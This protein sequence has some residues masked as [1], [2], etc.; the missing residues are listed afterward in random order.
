MNTNE[1]PLPYQM[2]KMIVAKWI[3][4]PVY[5]AAELGIADTLSQGGKRIEDLARITHTHAPTLYRVMRAL[6]SMGVFRE[7]ANRYFE[8]TPLA[9]C[10]QTGAMRSIALLFNGRWNDRAWEY[11]MDSVRTG[12]TAFEKA[13]GEPLFQW[14]D[15]HPEAARV[16]NEANAVKSMQ[17]HRAVVD[18]YDFSNIRRLTDVGGGNGAL[19]AEILAANP[20]MKGVVADI[21]G[22]AREARN[23]IRDRGLSGRCTIEECD[24]FNRIPPGSDA[25]LMS[26]ILHDW[27]DDMCMTL[28]KNSHR[29]MA[30]K[31]RLLVVEM[32]V[33]QGNDPSVAKMLDLEMLVMTGGRE[34][35]LPEF[36]H[37]LESA[38]FRLER[39]IPVQ[40]ELYIIESVPVT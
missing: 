38:G 29:A 3:S 36:R 20:G 27:P 5:V 25:Y 17:S 24:F 28:L 31:S 1:L 14:L 35:T 4:K 32:V 8:L 30:P 26:N 12:T 16:H 23:M 9:E 11:L 34:R 2:M 22:V 19:M 40:E 7:N 6:A 10:L 33:L 18:V 39:S 13:H 37:L 21:P 15:K